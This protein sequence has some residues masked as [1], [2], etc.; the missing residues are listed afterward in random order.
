MHSFGLIKEN[1]K[2]PIRISRQVSRLINQREE[3]SNNYTSLFSG[4]MNAKII[5]SNENFVDNNDSNVDGVT[6]KG[7]HLNFNNQKPQE[8]FQ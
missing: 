2:K 8:F 7:A 4:G 6:D 5:D 1:L 3:S